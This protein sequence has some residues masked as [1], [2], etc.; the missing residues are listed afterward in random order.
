MLA[1]LQANRSDRRKLRNL[2][3]MHT[4]NFEE[5]SLDLPS[6]TAEFERDKLLYWQ[7]LTESHQDA[8]ALFGAS[9]RGCATCVPSDDAPGRA[10]LL[11][12]SWQR[13]SSAVSHE[14]VCRTH[15]L[16]G[17]IRNDECDVRHAHLKPSSD[18]TVELQ[19]PSS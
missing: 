5:R 10:Q 1:G 11:A 9:L 2:Q 14:A 6:P 18:Q 7:P 19:R 12:D 13:F 15:V 3:S 4:T 8:T 16:H 17:Q